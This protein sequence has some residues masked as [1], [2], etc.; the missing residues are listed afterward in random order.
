MCELPFAAFWQHGFVALKLVEI[1][2]E[3]E[4]IFAQLLPQTG[5][6]LFGMPQG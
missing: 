2:L 1:G 3:F 4:H 5:P 6:V